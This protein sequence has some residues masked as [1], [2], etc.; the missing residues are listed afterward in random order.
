MNSSRR[1]SD[2]HNEPEAKHQ[3]QGN[4]SAFSLTHCFPRSCSVTQS[5]VLYCLVGLFFLQLIHPDQFEE[6]HTLYHSTGLQ[7]F[8]CSWCSLRWSQ[9]WASLSLASL[10]TSSLPI[11]IHSEKEKKKRDPSPLNGG[12]LID[13][14]EWTTLSSLCAVFTCFTW[15]ILTEVQWC[16]KKKAEKKKM[17]ERERESAHLHSLCVQW[18]E[19]ALEAYVNMT[20]DNHTVAILLR[21]PFP[22]RMWFLSA[23][24]ARKQWKGDNQRERE[25]DRRRGKSWVRSLSCVFT[26]VNRASYTRVYISWSIVQLP[27]AGRSL[28]QANVIQCRVW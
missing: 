28:T 2:P 23:R 3:L 21:V 8:V 25:R 22:L 24:V 15:F 11:T 12:H 5:T 17:R 1:K 10:D 16:E 26:W 27:E 9:R 7:R 19:G 4:K 6:T 18:L 13:R 14:Q 20:T